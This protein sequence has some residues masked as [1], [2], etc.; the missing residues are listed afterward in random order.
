MA[1]ALVDRPHLRLEDLVAELRG[2]EDHVLPFGGG[3]DGSLTVEAWLSWSFD[4]LSPA[5]AR[6]FRLVGLHFADEFS[7][8]DVAALAD[9]T[10]RE[11][12]QHLNALWSIHL[13]QQSS[14]QRYHFY[15]LELAYA[16]RR[17]RLDHGDADRT[18]ALRRL[19]EW[20]LH[21]SANA[22]RT[23]WSATETT[24]S[25][26][27]AVD[28]L[29]FTTA[30]D[31]LLW[32][33]T[34][35]STL[36]AAV[37]EAADLGTP[38]SWLLPLALHPHHVHVECLGEWHDGYATAL[39]AAR[40]AGDEHSEVTAHLALA[41]SSRALDDDVHAERHLVRAL[42]AARRLGLDHEESEALRELGTLHHHLGDPA[43][44][45][46][47]C[48]EA[49]RVAVA[50]HD[51]AGEAS[52]LHRLGLI[53]AD[54]GEHDDAIVAFG[55]ALRLREDLDLRIDV[56]ATCCELGLAHLRRHEPDEAFALCERV[57][58]TGGEHA[59]NRTDLTRALLVLGEIE[60]RR[61]NHF[62]A[63]THLHRSLALCHPLRDKAS[64]A[65]ALDLLGTSFRALGQ[66]DNANEEWQQ[67]LLLLTELDD[68]HAEH[69]RARLA[70][71]TST[72]IV[73]S[74]EDTALPGPDQAPPD[75]SS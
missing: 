46:E 5:T 65:H 71:L 38:E 45:V 73:L 49:R 66:S 13:I 61:G 75:R 9:T 6:T 48:E 40:K 33:R 28:P 18:A 29:T 24:G 41:A 74:S 25:A 57:V 14:H 15:G 44:G 43:S 27:S 47:R 64:A 23:L 37:R 17:F 70:D 51:R 67:A 31:A 63:L 20:Y 1:D 19:L 36:A 2:S 4:A 53:R 58:D 12:Q 68:P 22:V 26:K 35:R 10:P 8:G 30:R 72:R 32:L 42:A 62:K 55:R 7:A 21:T 60:H 52:S 39:R 56:A 69:I 59:A 11:A 16:R 50:A 3:E 34:E 54:R